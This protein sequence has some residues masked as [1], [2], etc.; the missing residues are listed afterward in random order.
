MTYETLPE[1]YK[2]IRTLYPFTVAGFKGDSLPVDGKET[3]YF[4]NDCLQWVEGYPE[5]KRI[6][7]SHYSGVSFQCVAC[8]AYMGFLITLHRNG[9]GRAAEI[10]EL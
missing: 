6:A 9:N 7:E 3:L 8:G 1:E 2:A 5:E 4:C 10:V